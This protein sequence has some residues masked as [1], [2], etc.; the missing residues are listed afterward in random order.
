MPQLQPQARTQVV[1]DMFGFHITNEH[2]HLYVS[3]DQLRKLISK[4]VPFLTPDEV[5]SIMEDCALAQDD[6]VNAHHG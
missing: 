3:A 5:N 2:G 4:L 6:A 1:K